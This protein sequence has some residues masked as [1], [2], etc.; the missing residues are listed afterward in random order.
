MGA[1]NLKDWGMTVP[2]SCAEDLTH[3]G[4]SSR[5]V[6]ALHVGGEEEGD[7]G[8]VGSQLGLL[9]LLPVGFL[10]GVGVG[11]QCFAER[12][13]PGCVGQGPERP[14]HCCGSSVG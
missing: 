11:W 7:G 12:L 10:G 9:K 5:E 14:W 3:Q 6:H 13:G 4:L 8:Y 1:V 2:D